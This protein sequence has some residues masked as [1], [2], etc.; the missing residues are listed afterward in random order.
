MFMVI[1]SASAALISF[2]I[3]AHMAVGFVTDMVRRSDM[4]RRIDRI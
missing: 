1:V 3:L 2:A 4:D